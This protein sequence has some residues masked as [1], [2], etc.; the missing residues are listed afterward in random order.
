MPAGANCTEGRRHE[1]AEERAV[2][3][4]DKE[5]GMVGTLLKP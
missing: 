3:A 2:R 1:C 5:D 4:V